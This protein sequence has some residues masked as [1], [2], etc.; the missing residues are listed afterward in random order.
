M[1]VNITTYFMRKICRYREVLKILVVD[2][3]SKILIFTFRAQ[4]LLLTI[5]VSVVFFEMKG[6]KNI[7]I[8]NTQD[9][10]TIVYLLLCFQV[11]NLITPVL[12]LKHS[13]FGMHPK[14]FMCT[15]KFIS[16][17]HR[18][19]SLNVF[20]GCTL[21]KSIFLPL[22]QGHFSMKLTSPSPPSSPMPPASPLSY[23]SVSSW[24]LHMSCVAIVM[25]YAKTPAILSSI[26]FT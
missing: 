13:Y 17:L 26:V 18:I 14:Y 16:S 20:K 7:W 3:F 10:K 25:I 21:M 9:W 11:W 22:H 24:I 8:L 12:F 2:V 23:L 15:S 5:I 6:S 4:I 19:F 1:L